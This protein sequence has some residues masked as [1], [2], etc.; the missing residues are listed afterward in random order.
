MAILPLNKTTIKLC[1]CFKL[2][3]EEAIP[4][5]PR[6]TPDK[7]KDKYAESEGSSVQKDTLPIDKKSGDKICSQ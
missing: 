1:S 3:G 7:G 5:L 6:L 2:A 4:R